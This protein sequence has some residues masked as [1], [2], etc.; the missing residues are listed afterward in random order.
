MCSLPM[1]AKIVEIKIHIYILHTL[2]TQSKLIAYCL[3]S[4]SEGY[5]RA[6]EWR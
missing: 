6:H 2:D 1:K 5:G 4:T 3:L